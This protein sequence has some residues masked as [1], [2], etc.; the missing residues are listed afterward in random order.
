[1][2]INVCGRLWCI[3]YSVTHA[4]PLFLSHIL[5]P[6]IRMGAADGISPP[7]VI[8]SLMYTMG[9]HIHRLE[10]LN[11]LSCSLK[12]PTATAFIQSV[13]SV[14]KPK[15]T[16]QAPDSSRPMAWADIIF[17]AR[18]SRKRSSSG[19]SMNRNTKTTYGWS[20]LRYGTVSRG[21]PFVWSLVEMI[22]IPW[23]SFF[24]FVSGPIF[25]QRES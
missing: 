12:I 8:I 5:S 24:V 7:S 17:T 25:P 18:R 22:R 20:S 11:M 21:Q 19:C 4:T 9:K 13:E 3:L 15:P 14:C 23:I 10:E 6:S 16:Y 1:M 2:N